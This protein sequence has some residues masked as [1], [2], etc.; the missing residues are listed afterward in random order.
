M[1]S[2]T[3]SNNI[4]LEKFKIDEDEMVVVKKIINKY[5]AK[6]KR[7]IEYTELRLEMK[8]RKK[9]KN[10]HFDISCYLFNPGTKLM[11]ANEDAN[12]FVAVDGVMSKMLTA[13]QHK[14]KIK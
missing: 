13:V 4:V 12:L 1:V 6:I 3:N 9:T 8:I 10:N 5:S 11:V 7:Y 2:G 14:I